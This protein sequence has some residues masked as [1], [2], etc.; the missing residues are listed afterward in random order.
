MLKRVRY[1][2]YKIIQDSFPLLRRK[3]VFFFVFWFRYYAMSLMIP[4]FI[5][6]VVFSTQAKKL[7]DKALTGLIV[8]EL[9]HQ[10]RYLKMGLLS[11]LSFILGYMFSKKIQVRE[12]HVT[13][14]MTIYK[15]YAR[16]LYELTLITRED[17]SHKK[18]IDNYLTPDE[19][20]EYALKIGKW[21]E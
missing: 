13:D 5:H 4:P 17:A 14:R 15:G 18:I 1:L 10:E 19:V 11:Y 12:E 8:H 20:R 9:C 21:R 3:K 7:N 2:A 16:E 6:I